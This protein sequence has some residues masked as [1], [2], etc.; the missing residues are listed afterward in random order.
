MLEIDGSQGEGGGQI[1]RS[2]LALS[3]ITQKPFKIINI[4]KKRPKSG[5]KQQHITAI[6]ALKLLSECKVMGDDIG[7]EELLF[8][9]APIKAKNALIDIGTAGSITLLL[10]ALLLPCTLANKKHTLTI[11]GGTDVAWSMPADYLKEIVI[12]QYCRIGGIEMRLFRRGYYPKGGGE[13]QISFKPRYKLKDFKT[14][15]C[16]IGALQERAFNLTEQG[17][18]IS[19]KGVSHASADLE[20][21]RVAERQASAAKSTLSSLSVP[22]LIDSHYSKTLSSGSG[23]TLWAIFSKN[24]EVNPEQPIRIGADA[25][26]EA[27]KPAE[28]VGGEAAIKLLEEINSGAPVDKHLADAIIPLMSIV[29]PS[30][31]RT[32]SITPHTRTNIRV[33]EQFFGKIFKEENTIISSQLN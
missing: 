28:A 7:S 2:A 23:L 15:K 8:V 19:I 26:G 1:V 16:L 29:R 3:M 24:G 27:G 12:P 20:S 17:K 25:L 21:A 22:I 5:L 6:N 30:T 9:P 32:S 14:T 18:L 31:I 11:R 13:I 33:A 10:Q 4:R